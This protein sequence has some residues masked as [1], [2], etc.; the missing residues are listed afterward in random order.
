QHL[1]DFR[2]KIAEIS[3]TN[4][5]DKTT[6]NVTVSIGAIFADANF[7][8]D[9]DIWIKQADDNLY[10]AKHQG[11]NCVICTQGV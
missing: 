9:L 3:I 11:R 2:Q 7:S 1:N 5:T 10:L 6:F 8:E 4:P